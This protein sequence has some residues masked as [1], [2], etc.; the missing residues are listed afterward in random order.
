MDITALVIA[1]I[2]LV[3]IN[4]LKAKVEEL[5]EQL[6]RLRRDGGGSGD[7]DSEDL[8][9]RVR[10]NSRFLARLAAGESLMP[11]QVREG[12]LWVDVSPE[13]AKVLVQDGIRILDVRTPQ[14]TASGVIPGAIQI[15]VDELPNRAEELPRDH[16]PTLVYCAA[17]VRSAVACQYL[18]EQGFDSLVNLDGGF[19]SWPG[20]KEKPA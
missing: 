11:S 20:A 10:M 14:E 12:H 19:S 6:D 7:V 13:Q 16:A 2:A 5:T 15:P 4:S 3:S 1:I 9:E 8:A 17:G 18:T